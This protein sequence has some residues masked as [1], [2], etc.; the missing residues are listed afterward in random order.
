[1]ADPIVREVDLVVLE[2][3]LRAAL[4]EMRRQLEAIEEAKK[5]SQETLRYEVTI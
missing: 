5:V 4:P 2:T 1:M 3:E